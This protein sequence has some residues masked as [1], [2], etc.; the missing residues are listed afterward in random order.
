MIDAVYGFLSTFWS[1]Q[2]PFYRGDYA[3]K[4]RDSG[5][6]IC[7]R[8]RLLLAVFSWCL[9]ASLQGKLCQNFPRKVNSLVDMAS[10]QHE[11]LYHI[12]KLDST[13][14]PFWKK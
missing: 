10:S 8:C 9:D 6:A 4:F 14:F 7:T 13:N 5:S 1:S 11:T 3:K 2:Y 12:K